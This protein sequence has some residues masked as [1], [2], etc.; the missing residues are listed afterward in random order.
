MSRPF[1]FF[2]FFL[3]SSSGIIDEKRKKGG[4]GKDLFTVGSD[5]EKRA[6]KTATTMHTRR[7]TATYDTRHER[8]PTF[9][10]AFFSGCLLVHFVCDTQ[11]ED[12]CISIFRCSVVGSIQSY[13]IENERPELTLCNECVSGIAQVW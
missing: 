2:F 6:R 5:V 11:G 8:E 12:L 7:I 4:G 10:C 3:P 1:L 13:Q 9:L